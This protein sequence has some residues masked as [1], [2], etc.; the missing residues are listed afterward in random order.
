MSLDNHGHNLRNNNYNEGGHLKQSGK[1]QFKNKDK[2]FKSKIDFAA[3][4]KIL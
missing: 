1:R 4:I 3:P 2:F